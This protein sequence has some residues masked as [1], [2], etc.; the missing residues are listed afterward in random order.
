ML[1]PVHAPVSPALPDPSTEEAALLAQL[2]LSRLPRHLAVIMDGNGRWAGRRH[3]PRIAGHQAGADA[4]R[5]T[6]ESAARLGIPALTLYAFSAEN[7]RRPRD[8][9]SFLMRLLRRFLR[10]EIEELNHN[11]IRLQWIGRREGLPTTV[12][13]DLDEACRATCANTG[14]VLTLALNYGAR[15]ELVDAVRALAA[16]VAAGT[17]RPEEIDEALIGR[18][19][20]TAGLPDPDLL[21]RSSGE[22]RISNF[23][24]WQIAY[25]EI[26][27]TPVLWPDFRRIHLLEAL[28]DFQRRERRFGGLSAPASGHWTARSGQ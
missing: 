15:H 10:A 26:W 19:L 22:W 17:L 9:V 1:P 24:L 18:H 4:V 20:Y 12:L 8:E 28:V 3:L 16:Q 7:W 11:N 27:I 5:A 13:T 23:L 21:I 14:M 25:A 6:T 2:D